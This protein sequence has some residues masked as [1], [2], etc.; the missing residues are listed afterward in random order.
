MANDKL[1]KELLGKLAGRKMTGNLKGDIQTLKENCNAIQVALAPKLEV[2]LAEY[3]EPCP[4]CFSGGEGRLAEIVWFGLNP[5]A[6]LDVWKKFNEDDT[7][8]DMAEFFAPPKGILHD[9]EN[10]YQYLVKNEMEGKKLGNYYYRSVFLVHQALVGN[11][12]ASYESWEEACENNGET[13][14]FADRFLP[15]LAEH[16]IL[17]TDL[18]P[19]KSSKMNLNADELI[20]DGNY[21]EYFKGLLQLAK[22]KSSN[23]AYIIFYGGVS[24]VKKLIRKWAELD[25]VK[26]WSRREIKRLQ[27]KNKDT[28]DIFLTK[29]HE[30]RTIILMPFRKQGR[31]DNIYSIK[32]LV[33]KIEDFRKK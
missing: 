8:Q 30:N 26:I 15:Q 12:K 7:W 10:A 11:P 17:N 29:W 24:F 5:G 16:P 28:V 31:E 23:D 4:F 1:F 25:K 22:E 18:I 27:K 32:D 19:Y 2:S 9:E 14:D 20:D 6:P 33:E 21:G 3:K 13:K